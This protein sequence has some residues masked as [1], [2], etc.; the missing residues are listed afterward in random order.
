[1]TLYTPCNF[2][3]HSVTKAVSYIVHTLQLSFP[4]CH[5]GHQ[6]HCTHL[7]TFLP[8]LS[9]RPSVTLYTP[10]NFP[11]LSVTKAVSYIVHTLQLSFPLCHQGHQLHCTYIAT[12]LPTLSPRPSVTL[13]IPCNFPS[14]SVTKA[15]SYIVRTLQLPFPL[16]H[17]GRQLHCTYLATFLP[18]LSPR[19]S[20]TLYI[21]CN[22]PSLSVTKAISYIVHTLQL[23]LPLCHQVRQLHCTHLATFL[24]TL[25]P[26]PSVTLYTPCDFPSHSVTEAVSDIVHTLQ[27]SFPLCHQGR[28]LHCTHLATFL[29]TLS[30]R[31]SVTLYIP[32]NFPSHSVTKAVSYIVHTLQLSFPLCHQGHQL[33]C[34]YI[35]T[36]LP[37]LSPRPSVT[38]YI[39]CNFPSHSVTKAISYIV[40]TLQLPFP[41]CHQ[42]RQLHCTYLAT[43]L[44]SLSPRPSVTLYIPCNFPSLSVTKAISYIVHTLQLSL[45]LCH[46]VRQLHC[47]HLAT[48]LPTLSPRPSVTLYTP[49]D[50]PSHSV[51]EAVSDIVHTLQLSF[52]LCHQ[53]R[54][55]HC[56]YLATFLPTLSP[57]PSVTLYV[58][59]NFPSHSV[60]K[61]VSYIVRTLQLSFPLCH[62]SRQLHCTYLATFLPTLSPR[63]S[64]TLYV[65]CNFP[66]L[67]VT[68]AVSYIVR[69]LQL[70]FPLCHQGRQLHCTYL[71]TSLPSLSPRPSVTLY[72]PCNFPS[73]SVTKAVSYIVHTLQL[74][75]PLCHQ[76][77]QLHCTYLA[78]S[79]PSLSPRPSVTLYIPCNFPSHSVTKAVSYIVRT[80]Q[81]S[82]PL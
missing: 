11:S 1:M 51:T 74:S 40:R 13:Y 72:I 59:C 25:S 68:K 9:P 44:P 19:P 3:S 53:G 42:G 35:A 7:A 70:S 65:P 2:P 64:V 24:P 55:L 4:L 78:T 39:P 69:T 15:I 63:P 23:S 38:L 21:P 52:P 47:T 29:P 30:P 6:L 43:F 10:C 49:C 33:H 76:G 37:T 62:Q 56:T 80:L 67:S 28:Q 82:F 71:A 57:R 18:S 22:F 31:P 45:P 17:Q 36:F 77:R 50:F 26:R 8:T 41:L 14:H 61:A 48:F 20:V 5:Q 81:L 54:Q 12:F 79:L 66:S 75:F 27:L 34:T 58:P 32:C 46:Q 73:H 60:T 16:C